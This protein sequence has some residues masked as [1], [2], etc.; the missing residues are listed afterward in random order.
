MCFFNVPRPPP[1]GN[2]GQIEGFGLGWGGLVGSD[3]KTQNKCAR[4]WGESRSLRAAR[5]PNV[6][7]N[8]RGARA[9]TH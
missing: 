9:R 2:G 1:T 4:L 8:V 3:T 7:T 6:E 5:L